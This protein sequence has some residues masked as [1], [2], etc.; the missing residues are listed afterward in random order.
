M[1]VDPLF[2]SVVDGA[3]VAVTTWR[4]NI[5]DSIVSEIERIVKAINT[6]MITSSEPIIRFVDKTPRKEVL[7]NIMQFYPTKGVVVTYE[8]ENMPTPSS[9][10]PSLY[11]YTFII[12][13][14]NPPAT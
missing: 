9:D 2:A 14:Q 10:N 8:S 6:I 1:Q 13:L 4:N 3:G 7:D 5:Q 11:D 12:A